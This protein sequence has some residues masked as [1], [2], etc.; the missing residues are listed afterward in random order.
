M[1]PEF[2]AGLEMTRK[3]LWHLRLPAPEIQQCTE[4]LRQ[5]LFGPMLEASGDYK[6]LAQ[7]RAAEQQFDLQWVLIEPGSTYIDKSI[8]EAE[9]R[10][11]TGA[12]VVGVIRNGQLEPNPGS[13]FRFQ[14]SDLVAIMGSDQAR[15][16]FRRFSKPDKA[17]V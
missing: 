10:K 3:V 1:L 15:D 16:S 7:L 8:G 5:E 9:I 12:S 17:T 13:Q 11:E 4:T 2:E 14:M 6:T